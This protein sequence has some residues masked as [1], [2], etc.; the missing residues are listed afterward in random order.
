MDFPDLKRLVQQGEHLQLEFKRKANHPDKIAREIVAFANTSGGQLLVGVDDD[1]QIYGSKTALEDAY[2]LE[3]YL[4]RYCY[5]HLAVQMTRVPVNGSREVLVITV[6]ESRIKP[7]FVRTLNGARSRTAYVRVADMS[8][9]AS[10][11]MVALLRH[12]RNEKGVRL[13]V[14]EPEKI[15]LQQFERQ[16]RMTLEEV[17]ALLGLPKRRTSLLMILLVRA[18]L[19]RIQATEKGDFYSLMAEAFE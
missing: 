19:V 11:E 8:I 1:K 7:H 9:T 5:P 12:G 4:L 10:R 3:Q 6:P 14:G 13:I 17:R 15:L 18:G 2:E 16:E